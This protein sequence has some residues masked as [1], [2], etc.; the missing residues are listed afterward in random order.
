MVVM[1]SAESDY[2]CDEAASWLIFFGG[3]GLVQG[4]PFLFWFVFVQKISDEL[5]VLFEGES[6][7]NQ[8]IHAQIMDV[9]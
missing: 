1:W 3:G 5:W 4:T 2:S 8:F 7:M 9:S 6:V